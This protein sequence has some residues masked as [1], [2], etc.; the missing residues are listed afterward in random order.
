MTRRVEYS[1]GKVV[2]VPILFVERTRGR[3]KMDTGIVI[4][5]MWRVTAWGVSRLF[6]IRRI[7]GGNRLR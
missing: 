7:P 2:E 1:G 6:R 3:S 4:E 5:A